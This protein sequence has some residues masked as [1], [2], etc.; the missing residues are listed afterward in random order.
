VRGLI[1]ATTGRVVERVSYDAY[2][3]ARHSFPGDTDGDGSFGAADL[4]ALNAATANN[5]VPRPITDANYNPDL[6]VNAD[7]TIDGGD[8]TALGVNPGTTLFAS[9]M[10]AG[11]ISSG[12]GGVGA[13]DNDVGYCGYMFNHETQD[14]HVRFRAYA[15][16]WGRWLQ[17]DPAGYVDGGSLVEYVKG[18][19]SQVVD[20][21]GLRS[22]VAESCGGDPCAPPSPRCLALLKKEN[23][24]LK[25]IARRCPTTSQKYLPKRPAPGSDELTWDES[26]PWVMLF[27]SVINTGVDIGE[28]VSGNAL[29]RSRKELARIPAQRGKKAI[30]RAALRLGVPGQYATNVLCKIGGSVLQIGS[31]AYS[32][33]KFVQ[34]VHEGN[35]RRMR[36]DGVSTGYGA[37]SIY[38]GA[39]GATAAG[40][41]AVLVLGVA[42]VAIVGSAVIVDYYSESQRAKNYDDEQNGTCKFLE[43]QFTDYRRKRIKECS[44]GRSAS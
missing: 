39:T 42:G 27:I 28:E 6:D 16:R 33:L 24:I 36:E 31:T 44:G 19:P 10:P 17:R 1:N 43:N 38:V 29:E 18:A 8:Y 11:R 22:V 32:A 12:G 26:E 37:L 7:G 21:Y 4:A 30:A 14:Y 2:G 5:T 13:P 25:A 15:P 34:A 23:D 3:V 9:A 20:P 35:G 40:Y 41:S